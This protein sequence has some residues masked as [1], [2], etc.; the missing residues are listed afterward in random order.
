MTTSVKRS[1]RRNSAV[2]I[3]WIYVPVGFHVEDYGIDSRYDLQVRYL[4]NSIWYY[5]VTGRRDDDAYVQLSS[6]F[7]GP[8]Y[9]RKNLVRTIREM[10][11]DAGLV[12]SDNHY[13]VGEKSIGYRLGERLRERPFVAWPVADHK[14]ERRF[15]KWKKA[16]NDLADLDE[17]GLY[18]S[19][20]IKKVRFAGDVGGVIARMT[21]SKA[22]VARAQLGYL[23]QGVVGLKYCAYGRFHSPYTRLCT[24]LRPHMHING[25][26]LF[27]VDVVNSQPTFLASIMRETHE[28]T[29]PTQDIQPQALT[30]SNSNPYEYPEDLDRFFRDV[31]GGVI[32]DRFQAVH[33]IATRGEAKDLFFKAVYGR[34]SN[35]GPFERIYPTVAGVLRRLKGEYGYKWVPCEMQR[36]EARVILRGAADRLRLEHPAVPVITIHDSIMTTAENLDLV[37]RII[38][39]AFKGEAVQPRLRVK[40]KPA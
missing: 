15:E 9:G 33:S 22:N 27:E 31:Q 30:T 23:D 36:R 25:N 40:V 10:C 37:E 34:V 13:I 18:F 24:E 14:S 20:W 28:K 1:G 6:S 21:A 17:L 16:E 3:G 7:L 35:L 12:E 11:V 29:H 19:S 38:R 26:P 2:R 5:K 8:L 4:L 39:E 32:Y